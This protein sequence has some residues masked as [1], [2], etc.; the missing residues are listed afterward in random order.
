MPKK[1]TE[2]GALA[3]TSLIEAVGIITL[4]LPTWRMSRRGMKFQNWL[5]QRG[6]AIHY[7]FATG[8]LA[9]TGLKVAKAFENDVDKDLAVPD[10][11]AS[12]Q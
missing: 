6:A 11:A 2:S 3:R 1:Y 12:D 10:A 7:V 9:A 4:V 8:V 5:Q